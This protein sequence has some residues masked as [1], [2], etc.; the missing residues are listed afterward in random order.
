MLNG[1]LLLKLQNA[2]SSSKLWFEVLRRTEPPL[3]PLNLL[4]FAIALTL[5]SGWFWLLVAASVLFLLVYHAEKPPWLLFCLFFAAVAFARFQNLSTPGVTKQ[6]GG[7]VSGR[8]IDYSTNSFV[9]S[10]EHG[11]FRIYLTNYQIFLR[12]LGLSFSGAPPCFKPAGF[13]ASEVARAQFYSSVVPYQKV[14]VRPYPSERNNRS[15]PRT[16]GL[17]PAY[18]GEIVTQAESAEENMSL[19]DIFAG[20]NKLVHQR[21]FAALKPGL[22]GIAFGMLSGIT[23]YIPDGMSEA[24]SRT[25][26]F[27]LLAVSGLHVGLVYLLTKNLLQSLKIRCG[28]N[29]LLSIAGSFIYVCLSGFQVSAVRALIM[30]SVYEISRLLMLGLNLKDVFHLT[31]LLFVMFRPA[32]VFSVSFQLSFG[33]IFA[34][35]YVFGGLRKLIQFSV[36]PDKLIDYLALTLS[37]NLTLIPLNIIYFKKI[38][39]LGM[40][41]NVFAVPLALPLL[42]LILLVAAFPSL[43]I[44]ARALQVLVSLLIGVVRFFS[45]IPLASLSPKG[46]LLVLLLGF[47]IWL[48]FRKSRFVLVLVCLLAAVWWVRPSFICFDVGEGGACLVKSGLHRCVLDTGPPRS[49]V[50]AKL[51]ANGTARVNELVISHFHLD[52]AGNLLNMALDPLL[53]IKKLYVPP[54]KNERE[55]TMVKLVSLLRPQTSVYIVDD[56][57]TIPLF[58]GHIDIVKPSIAC[59]EAQAEGNEDCLAA[60]V[61][62]GWIG[63]SKS[64]LYPADIPAESLIHLRTYNGFDVIVAPHHGSIDGFSPLLYRPPPE[65]VIISCGKNKYGH[66]S[67][68]LLDFLREEGIAYAVTQQHGDVEY[69]P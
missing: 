41:A 31:F 25:G 24:F 10:G 54:P 11:V 42:V 13:S 1:K 14:T 50:A 26:T 67:K 61:F 45:L 58:R 7:L 12:D 59:E 30:I 20:I 57:E 5:F 32:D 28:F 15:P 66:P 52:H 4:I 3:L 46:I 37:I 27:H 22:A 2:V 6:P 48:V 18:A 33:C 64:I 55:K 43:T 63:D 65:I 40:L 34:I 60:T 47:A 35:A 23:A 69:F 36:L 44:I 49:S 16:P 38:P 9:I 56:R 17:L 29:S 62:F 68:M 21:L 51:L 8:V 53:S 39:F 19:L